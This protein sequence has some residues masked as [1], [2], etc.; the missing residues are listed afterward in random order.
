MRLTAF[1][2]AILN[3]KLN[4]DVE[5]I[6]QCFCFSTKDGKSWTNI[7]QVIF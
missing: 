2:N 7:W 6:L 4:Y 5:N 1:S 3:D